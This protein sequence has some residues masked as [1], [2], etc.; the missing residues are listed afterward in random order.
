MAFQAANTALDGGDPRLSMDGGLGVTGYSPAQV[1]KTHDPNVSFE[2]YLYYAKLTRVE[3]A[4]LPTVPHP[5]RKIAGLTKKK[6]HHDLPEPDTHEGEK[7]K[8]QD[9]SPSSSDSGK[10]V[11]VSDEEWTRASRAMRTATWGAVFYLITTDILGP[12][13]VPWAMAQMGY[14]PGITLY[15]VFGAL[16]GYTGWQLWKMFLALDSNMYPLKTYGDF[17]YRIYGALVRHMINLLQS[18]QLLF[19]VGIIIIGNGQGIYQINPSICFIV[20]CVIWVACGMVLGQIR[21]L[22]KFGWIANFAIWINIV[23]LIMTMAVVSH[24][25]PNYDMSE[26]TNDIPRGDGIVHTYGGS[27]PYTEGFTSGIVGLM[28]AVYSFGGAMLF[29]EFMSEMRRPMDFWKSLILAET[30]IYCVYIF[31][32]VYVY[33]MQGQYT[34]NPANQGMSPKAA[35][36][37][38]NIISF[39]SSLIAAALYGNIGIKVSPAPYSRASA[40]FADPRMPF[41]IPPL[42]VIYSNILVELFKFP[43]LTKRTGKFLWIG[44]VPIY[45]SIA[46]VIAA[47]IPNFSALSGLVAAV[48]ILQFTYTFPPFL[49]IGFMV[50]SDAM[51]EGEGYDPA[52]RQTIRH[53]SGM[54]RWVRGYSKNWLMNTW[55]LV[56]M[57][58]ALVTAGLGCY[59]SIESLISAFQ[60]GSNTAFSCSH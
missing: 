42:Q 40:T 25:R 20:C 50:K 12:Y 41:L 34:I 32:G 35:Y 28:Q 13:S 36:T 49:M 1:R 19:N 44:L 18:I 29:A 47:S 52:T 2:E 16:A 38:G 53:D 37:A 11:V 7:E 39:I 56:F 31:F 59:S 54:K 17:A 8:K 9:I 21:T 51:Q 33:A 15:T 3:E 10:P 55:N 26:E 60:S 23:V 6:S 4:E 24:S 46:F 30:F 27:P 14:G 43:P 22:Q 45:W 5:F 57:L 58:G 48:C